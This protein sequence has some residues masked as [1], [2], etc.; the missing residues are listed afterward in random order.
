[1]RSWERIKC[2]FYYDPM[3]ATYE[4]S[5]PGYPDDIEKKIEDCFHTIDREDIN[6]I[7][8]PT[9]NCVIWVV[10]RQIR[11]VER[12]QHEEVIVCQIPAPFYIL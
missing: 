3:K 10:E 6:R 2:R 7:F 12:I 1:M 5:V 9:V 8:D 11:A 4:V